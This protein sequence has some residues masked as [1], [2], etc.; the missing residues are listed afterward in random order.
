MEAAKYSTR[1]KII[2]LTFFLDENKFI[3]VHCY[4]KSSAIWL[5]ICRLSDYKWPEATIGKCINSFET[6]AW[7]CGQQEYYAALKLFTN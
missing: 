1:K 3:V 4:F 7:L 2:G 6:L 5:R